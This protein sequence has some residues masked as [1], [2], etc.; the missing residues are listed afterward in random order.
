MKIKYKYFRTKLI[1]LLVIP[2]GNP[3]TSVLPTPEVRGRLMEYLY[4]VLFYVV[5]QEL[6]KAG[7]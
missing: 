1:I 3:L 7:V 4:L 6:Y 5:K 2:A